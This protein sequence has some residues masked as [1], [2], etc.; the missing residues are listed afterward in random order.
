MRQ[1]IKFVAALSVSFAPL[2]AMAGGIDASRVHPASVEPLA[3]EPLPLRKPPV[4]DLP[5][6][7]VAGLPQ[8]FAT[9][10]AVPDAARAALANVGRNGTKEKIR[11]IRSAPSG[12]PDTRR[13][14][15]VYDAARPEAAEDWLAFLGG[16]LPQDH[17]GFAVRATEAARSLA[18]GSCLSVGSGAVFCGTVAERLRTMAAK[19]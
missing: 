11:L 13:L 18:P 2:A 10:P 7:V 14:Q 12:G 16:T 5:L 4:R 19:G 17:P 3:V 9:S 15:I 8:G 6:A 1:F